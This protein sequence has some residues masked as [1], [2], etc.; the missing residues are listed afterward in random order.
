ML[1]HNSQAAVADIK[2]NRPEFPRETLKNL[3]DF[4]KIPERHPPSFP[5]KQM[6]FADAEYA[7]KRK[8][9]RKDG[10][11]Q[12]S[13]RVS[14]VSYAAILSAGCSLSGLSVTAP[15][16]CQFLVLPDQRCGC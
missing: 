11:L 3:P 2:V 8:Q 10:V 4:G 13:C 7:G 1:I 9:A 6:T 16:G 5:M 14:R 15:I 12:G